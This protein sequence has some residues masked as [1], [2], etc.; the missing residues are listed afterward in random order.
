MK[1]IGFTN[2]QLSAAIAWQAS[3][4]AVGGIVAGVPLGIV[5]GR[6]LWIR[7]ARSIAAVAEP[8]VPVVATVLMAVGSRSS[9]PT[10]LPPC[11]AE[12][13][14]HTKTAILLRSE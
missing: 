4:A 13:P 10:S 11:R 2:R 6:Q 14:A 9:S 12:S 7:F 5:V 1:V 3:V 8:T